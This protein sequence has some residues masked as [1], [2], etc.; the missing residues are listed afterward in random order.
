MPVG[1][2]YSREEDGRA[3]RKARAGDRGAFRELV[4]RH[5]RLVFHV[6]LRMTGNPDTAADLS[7]D[8]FVKAFES[9]RKLKDSA[10]FRSWLISIAVNR[11]HDYLKDIRR[12]VGS[13][14]D[15]SVFDQSLFS[16]SI[17]NP[18]EG[19]DRAELGRSL[20]K[21]LGILRPI[22]REA[23]ILKDVE[24]LSYEEM[25]EITGVSIVNLKI[26]VVRGRAALREILK[27]WNVRQG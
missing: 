19:A 27:Q 1:A 14:E 9:L 25:K 6:A 11:C 12:G 10:S 15:E 20:E 23:V 17:V 22:Y 3:V 16:G 26:R 2:G 21:A 7:Q 8:V 4:E 13:I 24:E 18:G 5:K